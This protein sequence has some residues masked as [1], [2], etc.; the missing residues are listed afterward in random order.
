[1]SS[2]SNPKVTH[3][4]KLAYWFEMLHKNKEYAK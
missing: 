1:M 2:I 4:E 3:T